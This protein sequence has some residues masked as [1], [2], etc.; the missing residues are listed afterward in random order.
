MFTPVIDLSVLTKAT[1]LRFTDCTLNDIGD[2]TKWDGIAGISSLNVSTAQIKVTDPNGDIYL[3][4][5]TAKINAAWPVTNDIIFDDITGEFVDGFYTV[6]Y[7]VWMIPTVI[8][9][10]EDYGLGRVKINSNSHGIQTGM[11][12]TIIG[13]NGYY[14][15]FHDAVKID[16]NSFY[17]T[18]DFAGTDTGTST[19]CYSNLFRPHVFANAEMAINNMLAVYCNMNEGPEADEYMKQVRTLHG[20]LLALR[21]AIMTT[22]E[23]KVNNIYGRITRILDFNSVELTYS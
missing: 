1:I 5:C 23:D 17:I 7:D 13:V 20:L 19:P 18:T 14:D 9:S 16:D 10:A 4:D 11:K 15:G 21:S 8:L 22:T 6:Q 3:L 2:G 12:V